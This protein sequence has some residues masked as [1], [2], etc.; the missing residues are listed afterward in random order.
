MIN[1]AG[2]GELKHQLKYQDFKLTSIAYTYRMCI[3]KDQIS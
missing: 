3:S 1:I 2:V